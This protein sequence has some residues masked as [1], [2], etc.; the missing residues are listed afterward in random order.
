M[1][2]CLLV[3]ALT[4]GWQDFNNACEF[5]YQCL[6]TDIKTKVVAQLISGILEDPAFNVQLCHAPSVALELTACVA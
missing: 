1:S 5:Y 4:I 3:H 2:A 6:A